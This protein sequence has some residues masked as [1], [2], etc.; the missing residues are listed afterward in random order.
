M[1]VGLSSAL[2]RT[3]STAQ[4]LFFAQIQTKRT[5]MFCSICQILNNF[6]LS[7]SEIKLIAINNEKQQVKY[8]NANRYQVVYICRPTVTFIELLSIL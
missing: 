1:G 8:L 4:A 7:G 5:K 3:A 2:R 6:S